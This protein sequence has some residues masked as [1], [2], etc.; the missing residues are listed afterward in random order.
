MQ[1][2]PSEHDYEK[3]EAHAKATM[4]NWMN[5]QRPVFSMVTE[6]NGRLLDQAIRV[7]TAWMGFIGRQIGQEI[8][9]TRRLLECRTMQDFVTTYSD[10]VTTAQR[11]VHTEIEE[12]SR[13]NREAAG[14][15]MEAV[16][17]GLSEA[18]E[19]LRH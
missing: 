8:N 2:T 19:E 3:L 6:I 1:I 13:I 15:A 14:E 9:A 4:T 18:A 5:M 11:E 17:A 10:V 12:L 16:R 7:N